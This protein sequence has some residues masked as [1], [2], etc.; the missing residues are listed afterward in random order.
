MDLFELAIIK[1][2]AG[3]C[4]GE[5]II[6]SSSSDALLYLVESDIVTPAFYDGVFF[7]ASTGEIYVI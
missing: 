4:A 2:L 1:A 5:D 7:T 3:N 6:S